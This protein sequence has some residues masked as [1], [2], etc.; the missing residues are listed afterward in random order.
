MLRRHQ[1]GVVAKRLELAA[2]VM[3]T[4]TGLDANQARRP[5][6]QPCFDLTSRLP[7][8]Q[9]QGASASRPTTWN[10]FLPISMPMTT[11]R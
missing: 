9:H 11:T 7:L 3:C 6:G 5:S 1:P 10:Q 4:D 8:T 2:E